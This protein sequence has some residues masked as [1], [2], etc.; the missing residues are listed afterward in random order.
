MNN[1]TLQRAKDLEIQ[2]ADLRKHSE[3]VKTNS[4][5]PY[6]GDSEI[7]IQTCNSDTRRRLIKGFLPITL[8]EF[9]EMYLTKVG[10]EIKRLEKEFEKL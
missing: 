7:A 4:E 5:N 3:Y 10:K 6:E 2:I 8:P 1:E 9:V